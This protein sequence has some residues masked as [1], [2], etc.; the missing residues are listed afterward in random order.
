MTDDRSLE[1][2]IEVPGTPEE[3][4]Q[5]IATG[6]GISS[7]YVPHTITEEEGGAASSS[8]GPGPEMTVPGRVAAWDP[9][10]RI[11]LTGEGGDDVGLAFE[12]LVE[13][14]DGGSCVVRLVNSGFG[15][16]EQWDEQYDGMSKGWPMF[17]TNLRLHREHFAGQH[18]TP[19]IPMGVWPGAEADAWKRLTDD[20]GIDPNPAVGDTVELAAADAPTVAGTVMETTPSRMSLLVEK[21]LPGTAIVTAEQ[22]GDVVG[23]SLWL[24]LY[25]DD[26]E[27]AAD[28]H[29]EAWGA[30]LSA[31]A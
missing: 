16:G 27:S 7:W 2:E 22:M 8:F 3:V 4:W 19:S 5:A 1:F 9:P 10:K 26:R 12:W 13:A 28:A 14:R 15:S 23:V 21:P 6:P 29:R 30:W 24:Y 25:G 11:V 17:L 18:A 31:R 20:L